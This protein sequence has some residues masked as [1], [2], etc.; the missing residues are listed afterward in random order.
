[1]LRCQDLSLPLLLAVSCAPPP[2]AGDTAEIAAPAGSPALTVSARALDLGAVVVG[3]DASAS[4]RAQN[5]GDALLRLLAPQV[6]GD[7]PWWVEGEPAA[8]L[9]PGEA[10]AWVVGVAPVRD[11]PLAASLV[12]RSDDPAA[13]ERRVSLTATGQAPI[14]QLTP[15]PADLGA[16]PLGCSF[17]QTF[18]L[19]NAGSAP[20]HVD[21]VALEA[22]SPGF[23]LDGPPPDTVAPGGAATWVTDRFDLPARPRA[24]LWLFVD[25]SGTMGGE[26]PA[27]EAAAGALVEQ[28]AAAQGDVRAAAFVSDDGCVAGATPWLD[29]DTPVSA[30]EP[31][32]ADML[33]GTWGRHT[34]AAFSLM[35]AALEQTAPGGCNEALR[36]PD[37]SLHLVAISDEPEQSVYDHTH[38]LPRFEAWAPTPGDLV[39]HGMGGP[40]PAGCGLALAYD[41]V[42]PA[43][44]A[45]GGTFTSLCTVDWAATLAQLV[46]ASEA[47]PEAFALSRP[48]VSST[49][50]V[51]VDGVSARS[52]W[53]WDAADGA[54]AFDPAA[55]P[56]PGA[57]VQVTYAV[58]PT[59][60][61]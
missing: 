26:Q 45:T 48:P 51:K 61:R 19:E 47:L 31:A 5:D 6:T 40:P 52:G 59:C 9:Q 29:A 44:V 13:P 15:A 58:E 43:T 34:E 30:A 39:V 35:E 8:T 38:Y 27:L 32:L 22:S 56:G 4:V 1:M 50:R 2:G 14:A 3:E 7:G 37:A 20:L 54:V 42:Y 28:L 10:A 57:V 17:R 12:L 24:D 33:D 18:S 11:G 46:D 36:R 21:A 53:S 41:G 23:A 49:L 60:E 55:A 25:R 16:V